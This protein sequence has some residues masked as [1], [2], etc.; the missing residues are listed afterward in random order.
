MGVVACGLRA[1][2]SG[3]SVVA[4]GLWVVVVSVGSGDFGRG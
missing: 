2:S 1:G 3:V 4:Y